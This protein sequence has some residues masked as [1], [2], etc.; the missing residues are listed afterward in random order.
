MSAQG[1]RHLS[2]QQLSSL[3]PVS[4]FSSDC[5]LFTFT[6]SPT[7]AHPRTQHTRHALASRSAI[8]RRSER[9]AAWHKVLAVRRG[10]KVRR[11]GKEVRS[12]VRS[13]LFFSFSDFLLLMFCRVL[14]S[15]APLPPHIPALLPLLCR[16]LLHPGHTSRP[17]PSFSFCGLGSAQGQAGDCRRRFVTHFNSCKSLLRQSAC[18]HSLCVSLPADESECVNADH[19]LLLITKRSKDGT[20]V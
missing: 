11:T 19:T 1:K 18:S 8:N 10:E 7:C 2:R 14:L 20:C 12:Y 16:P 9:T 17:S 6:S 15:F 4:D 5:H 3:F 13:L